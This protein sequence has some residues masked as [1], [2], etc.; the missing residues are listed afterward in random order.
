MILECKKLNKKYK[1][2]KLVLNNIDLE[3]KKGEIIG[4]LGPNGAGK[5]TLIKII[6]GLLTPTNYEK[7]FI[8]DEKYELLNKKK[9][10]LTSSANQLY[11][12]LTALENLYFF[13]SLYNIKVCEETL[14]K[15]LNLVGLKGMENTLVKD[16]SFG[17][18][19]KLNVGK[20]IITKAEFLI[21]DEPTNGLDPLS[22]RELY[23]LFLELQESGRTILISSHNMNEIEELCSRVIIMN[24]GKIIIDSNTAELYEKYNGKIHSFITKLSL[25]EINR[26]LINYK[27]RYYIKKEAEKLLVVFFEDSLNFK[28]MQSLLKAEDYRMHNI[29][30]EDIFLYEINTSKE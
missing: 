15:T 24:Q 9:I 19:Q 7:F 4:L 20:S 1:S 8:F 6:T 30:M 23:K 13:S 27:F 28:E 17:M 10:A 3:I 21:F 2:E 22:I 11:D 25:E 26:K 16:F 5:T 29:R 18:K 14:L 12:E